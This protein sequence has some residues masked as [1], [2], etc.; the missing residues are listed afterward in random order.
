MADGWRVRAGELTG[1]TQ[2][3]LNTMHRYNRA[4][5]RLMNP[6]YTQTSKDSLEPSH[7]QDT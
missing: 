5:R 6:L 2:V 7:Q 3:R 4:F 1:D